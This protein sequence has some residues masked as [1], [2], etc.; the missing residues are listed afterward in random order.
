MSGLVGIYSKSIRKSI[1]TDKLLRDMAQEITYIDTD[2]VDTW[3]DSTFAVT[4][5]HHNITNTETQP[6]FNEDKSLCIFMDGEVFGYE[7]EK[8]EL[9]KKGHRFK[10][11]DNDAEFCLHLYEEYGDN[12]FRKLN[13]SFLIVIYKINLEE[14]IL[15]NDRL[16]SRHVFY[17]H[18]KNK[19][20]F[21]SQLRPILKFRWFKKE[22][23]L[24][25]VFEFFTFQKI[26]DNRTYYKDSKILPK[27]TILYFHGD[28][29]KTRQYWEMDYNIGN[30][31]QKYYVDLLNDTL[32]K[33]LARRIG[34]N[35]R[36]G[37]LLSGG[38]D[39]RIILAADRQHKIKTTFT[40]GDF[41]NREA[42]IAKRVAN[43]A[44]CRHF[45]LK[46]DLDHYSRIVDEA[47][48]IGDGMYLFNHAHFLGFS[49]D[50][51]KYCDILFSGFAFN[52][53]LRG[54][55]VINRELI[56]GGKIIKLP[57]LLK[58]IDLEKESDKL[59]QKIPTSTFYLNPEKI[60]NPEYIINYEDIKRK[61]VLQLINEIKL[62]GNRSFFEYLTLSP[63][64]DYSAYLNFLSVQSKMELRILITDNDLLEL[65]LSIPPRFKMNGLVFKSALKKISPELTSIIDGGA[66]M[67]VDIHP[68]RVRFIEEIRRLTNRIGFQNKEK[69]PHPTFTNKSWPNWNNFISYNENMKELI[70]STINDTECLNPEIFNIEEIKNIFYRQIKT[71]DNSYIL[72]NLLLTFGRWYKKYG[73]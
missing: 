57:I 59:S 45:F 62:T 6:I 61:A 31:P 63:L 22:L 20:I 23:N 40:L 19:L 66:N 27:A 32:I 5:V 51:L 15:V 4:R 34:D 68:W 14:L 11:E 71:K 73:P 2:V 36:I 3:N 29:F 26:F 10:C 7:K 60:F 12:A 44:G 48:D 30:Y 70:W 16:S 25:S 65:A 21:A 53:I 1:N 67:P 49:K 58:T 56:L 52:V 18:N 33:A 17:Y 47:V 41:E 38:L 24:Q 13:G 28:K 8:Q 42:R 50:F 54:H 9:I 64:S 35:N 72:L 43:K 69:L 39:S 46:R 37:L 55:L